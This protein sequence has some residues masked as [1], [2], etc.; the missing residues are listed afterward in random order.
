MRRAPILVALLAL[1]ALHCSGSESPVDER[2]TRESTGG[3]S[4]TGGTPEIPTGGPLALNGCK[5]SDYEDRSAEDADRT[6]LIAAEGVVYTPRCMTVAAGQTVHWE[7]R[8]SAHPMS[9][10]NSDNEAAGSRGNPI[11]PTSTGDGVDFTF[12][13][14]GTFPYYCE[15]HSSGAGSGMA[16]A[17]YVVAEF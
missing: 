1:G 3:S 13:N 4:N 2:G 11:V 16:G 12:E 9:P 7:G 15:V 8:L 10:G 17:I 6:V 14:A 5:A